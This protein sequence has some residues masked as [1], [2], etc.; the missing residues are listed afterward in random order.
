MVP[1]S[2][3]GFGFGLDPGFRGRYLF[4]RVR[5]LG[6]VHVHIVLDVLEFG[7]GKFGL[8]SLQQVDTA[9]GVGT[10]VVVDHHAA[11][12]DAAFEVVR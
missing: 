11:A 12:Q 7:I 4:L 2:T 9:A 8:G 3:L 10:A 1:D 6:R 5:C